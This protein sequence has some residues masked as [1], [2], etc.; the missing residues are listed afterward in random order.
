MSTGPGYCS[1]EE[2][3]KG[4]KE[5]MLY[6]TCIATAEGKPDY[7]AVVDIKEGSPTF[8]QVERIPLNNYQS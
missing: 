8:C 4:P 2:A 7:L 1:P 3:M 5:E 6:V